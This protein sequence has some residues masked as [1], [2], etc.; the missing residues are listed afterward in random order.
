MG[1]FSVSLT[2]VIKDDDKD[3]H[4]VLEW[5]PLKG[6]KKAKGEVQLLIRVNAKKG[7]S[8]G[9]SEKSTEVSAVKMAEEVRKAYI[10]SKQQILST[11]QESAVGDYVTIQPPP[12]VSASR[13][14]PFSISLS[15]KLKTSE[16]FSPDL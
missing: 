9:P 2:H 5:F 14:S 1:E 12:P 11:V 13:P 6:K 15:S 7:G 3:L 8:E 4:E 10:N 16:T